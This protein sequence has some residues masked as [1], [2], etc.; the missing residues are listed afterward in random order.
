MYFKDFHDPQNQML[1]K[2]QLPD[3]PD[4]SVFLQY[5]ER[6]KSLQIKR[7]AS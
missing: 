3:T 1:D 6:K 7:N 2:R 4:T 5:S